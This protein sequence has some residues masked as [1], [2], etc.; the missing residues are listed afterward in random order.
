MSVLVSDPA[1]IAAAAPIRTS[2]ALGNAGNASISSGTVVD[3]THADLLGTTT[4]EFLTPTTYSINGAGSFAYTSGAD[5]V[6]NGASVRISGTPVAGDQF[7]ISSNA[8]GV[9]DNRNA[10]AI[11]AALGAGVLDGGSVTLQSAANSLVTSIGT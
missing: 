2:A 8:G 9:G 5:I 7:V 11:A 10:L 1:R 4:I 6:V 3:V